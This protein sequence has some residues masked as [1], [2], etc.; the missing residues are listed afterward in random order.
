MYIHIFFSSNNNLPKNLL[1][2]RRLIDS[3][4]ISTYIHIEVDSFA[5][6][7]AHK[8]TNVVVLIYFVMWI[9]VPS[10][11]ISNLIIMPKFSIV[12]SRIIWIKNRHLC[13]YDIIFEVQQ[14]FLNIVLN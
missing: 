3:K 8:P 12:S 10:F 5:Q 11:L 6:V 13:I 2:S 7:F 1:H 14:N 4:S 9:I